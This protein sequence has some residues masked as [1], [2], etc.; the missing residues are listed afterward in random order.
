MTRSKNRIIR[1][2]LLE[3]FEQQIA[4]SKML[5]LHSPQGLQD[6]TCQRDVF[7]V[8]AALQIGNHLLFTLNVM[9]AIQHS[10][11]G[12]SQMFQFDLAVH[13]HLPDYFH[14]NRMHEIDLAQR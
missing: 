13:G 2:T 5:I 12:D 9:L 11:L 14:R 4:V 8:A 10:L 3:H 7:A 1:A 6:F